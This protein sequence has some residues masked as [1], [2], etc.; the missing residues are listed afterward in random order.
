[1]TYWMPVPAKDPVMV[2]CSRGEGGVMEEQ[3]S[4][5]AGVMELWWRSDGGVMEL[6]LSSNGVMV[7]E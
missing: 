7:E 3:W 1:M 6:W 4:N 2:T 5:G